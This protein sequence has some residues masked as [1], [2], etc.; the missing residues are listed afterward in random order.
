M[1]NHIALCVIHKGLAHASNYIL[2]TLNSLKHIR[3]TINV[4][5]RYLIEEFKKDS[6]DIN[7]IET[8]E[9]PADVLT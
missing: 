3:F 1:H 7:Y 2:Q 4:R 9:Q 8:K 6:S 5:T